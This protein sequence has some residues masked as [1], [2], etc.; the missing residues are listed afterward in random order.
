MLTSAPALAIDSPGYDSAGSRPQPLP[1]IS[2]ASNRNLARSQES[3]RELLKHPGVWRR[4]AAA[5]QRIRT[6]STGVPEL[7]ALLPGGGWPCGA[8]SEI[9]FAHDG[10]GELS[11]LMPALAELT[12]R[13]QRVVFIAPP[14]IPYAPALVEMG[15]DLRHVVQIESSPAAGAWSAEQCLRSGSCGAVLSW[16]QQGTGDRA[17]KPRESGGGTHGW[18]NRSADPAKPNPDTRAWRTPATAGH[19]SASL[20]TTYTQLRRLQLAAESG[21]ALAFLFRPA[22]SAGKASP[23]ALRLRLRADNDAQL[24]I[25]ILKCRGSLD[26]RSGRSTRLRRTA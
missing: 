7:D 23:A 14:Y 18:R 16:L 12:R 5:Q 22:Q 17:Q 9:L 10:I 24:D 11:L 25:E 20:E 8:L 13:Q 2:T 3:L 6:L 1:Q 26:Q 19:Q 21:D 15:L 4:S